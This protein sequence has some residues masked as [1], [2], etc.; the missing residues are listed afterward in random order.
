M[1]EQELGV[2]PYGDPGRG[3]HVA[4]R[5]GRQ[6]YRR[7]NPL[8]GPCRGNLATDGG[9]RHGQHRYIC[10][11]QDL[12]GRRSKKQLARAAQPLS[13]HDDEVGRQTT[14]RPGNLIGRISLHDGACDLPDR[15][16][17][18]H[19]TADEVLELLFA[20]PFE[21]LA[22]VRGRGRGRNEQGIADKECG[23]APARAAGD[24]RS[25]LQRCARMRREVDWAKN[26]AKE[27]TTGR[28]AH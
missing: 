3:A 25:M 20:G 18:A 8:P 5:M 2:G 16:H 4:C 14:D 22:V 27:V 7:K 10:P 19:G 15:E 26:G 11:P 28:H 21:G 12:L 23:E 9:R 6:V 24:D 17:L 13:P 1:N